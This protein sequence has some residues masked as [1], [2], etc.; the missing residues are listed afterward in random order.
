MRALLPTLCS[1]ALFASLLLFCAPLFA[2]AEVEQASC[3]NIALAPSLLGARNACNAPSRAPSSGDIFSVADIRIVSLAPQ[4]GN[5]TSDL[6]NA[7]AIWSWSADFPQEARFPI[8]E[9]A[10]CPDGE[11]RY[12]APSSPSLSGALS[13]LY[14]NSTETLA[15]F[16]NGAN[17][18]PLNLSAGKLAASDF[19]QPF[20]SLSIALRANISIAYSF[21]KSGYSYQ[22]SSING[23]VAC[24]CGRNFDSGFRTFQRSVFDARNFSVETGPDSVLWLNPPLSSRLSGDEAGKI[25]LFARRLPANLSLVFRGKEIASV[26]PYSFS[27]RTGACGE[28]IVEREFLPA[29]ASAGVFINTSAPIFPSQLVDRNASY[30]P[31]YLEFPWHADAGRANFTV[32]Y[33]D[34]FSRQ[35]AFSREFS[36]REPAPFFSPSGAA[37]AG[38]AIEL[39]SGTFARACQGQGAMERREASESATSAA[40]PALPQQ[41]AFPDFL[42]LAAAFSLPLALSAAALCRRFEWW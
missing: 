10:R 38:G 42:L 31:F 2:V 20:A 29:R 1:M 14:G 7:S 5:A 4:V 16:S 24:G 18:S 21:S 30:A 13:Y 19:L 3:R 11:I 25:A 27:V 33:E 15:L 23:Y 28:A 6:S 9:D 34:A 39:C 32:I 17:P 26:Q 40:Y 35:Q 22:C 37:G 36:V 12:F 41:A 8:K